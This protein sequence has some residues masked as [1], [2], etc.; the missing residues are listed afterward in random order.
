MV[1]GELPIGSDTPHVEISLRRFQ[2]LVF[3]IER[4]YL[5]FDFD[6]KEIMM[7]DWLIV[8]SLNNI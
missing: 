2:L 6:V 7:M 5:L 3:V 8:H 1:E 4:S